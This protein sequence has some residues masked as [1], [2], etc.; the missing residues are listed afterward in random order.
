MIN[1]VDCDVH[2]APRTFDALLP[3]MDK[4]WEDYIANAELFLEP[5]MNGMY[6]PIALKRDAAGDSIAVPAT[7]EE[8]RASMPS[9]G[10]SPDLTIINCIRSF[11]VSRNPY[12]EATMCSAI[13]DWVAKEWLECDDR[14]RA[15]L[16]LPTLDVRAAVNEI[17]RLGDHPG[18]VQVLMPIRTDTPY[19]QALYHP[20]YAAAESHK[21]PLALH[22]WGRIGNAPTASGFTHSYMEN[23]VSNELAIAPMQVT[24]MVSEGVFESFPGLEVAVLECGFLWLP[25]HLWRFDKDWKGIWREVPWVKSLP[26]EYVLRHFKFST[27]PAHLP[28]D[29]GV[30]ERLNELLPWSRLLM[31]ASDHPHNHGAGV[32]RLLETMDEPGRAAVMSGNASR[33]Y[34]LDE[35]TDQLSTTSSGPD[36]SER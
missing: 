26:S 21:L 23:Y 7:L 9:E 12:Y 27:T 29:S 6:P 17:E 16:V 33:F 32:E 13:N 10:G 28:A 18:F 34:R 15:S 5:S 24:S 14:L 31:Y 36:A 11:D 3:Y 1:T 2:I 8:L 35:S 30:L 25:F 22:A 4:Y 20:I 19:G